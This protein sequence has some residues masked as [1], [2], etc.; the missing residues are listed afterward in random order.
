M[1]PVVPED[2]VVLGDV[3]RVDVVVPCYETETLASALTTLRAVGE[4][5]DAHAVATLARQHGASQL[6]VGVPWR[7]DGSTGP[8]AAK[9]LAFVER[10]RRSLRIPAEYRGST[11]GVSVKV[12]VDAAGKPG[13][14][15]PL[16]PMPEE[17]LGAIATAVR[18][19]AWT[20]GGDAD[21][22]P[23]P[24]WTMVTVR[25]DGR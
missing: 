13:P 11:G 2:A 8:Q 5:K 22:R 24:L 25:L 7:L 21:G 17:I 3:E 18:S 12:A 14:V 6:V 15:Y 4:R 23:I 1:G 10:L 19:C 16:A 9:V 20:A